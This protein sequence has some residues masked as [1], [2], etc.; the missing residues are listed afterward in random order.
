MAKR[1]AAEEYFAALEFELNRERAAVLGRYGRKVEA[2]LRAIDGLCLQREALGLLDHAREGERVTRIELAFS[3][4]EADVLPLNY[5]RG[6]LG[7][8][9]E[10]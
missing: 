8:R 5:T 4:W 10:R 2:A 3:A 7:D 9:S 1:S 6:Q